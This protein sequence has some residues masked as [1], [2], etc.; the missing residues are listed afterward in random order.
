MPMRPLRGIADFGNVLPCPGRPPIVRM[1]TGEH[2]MHPLQP[3]QIN[4][5]PSGLPTFLSADRCDDLSQLEAD[6]AIVGVPYGVPYDLPGMRSPSATAPAAI[7]AASTRFVRYLSHYDFDLGGPVFA[8]RDIRIIDCGD[9]AMNAGDFEG[10]SQRTTTVIET[11]RDRGAVPIILGGDHA[12]PIP[13]MRAYRDI[14]SM[15][16]IQLDAHIDWRHEVDG[17][18]EGLSSPMR[19]ASELPYVNGMAQFGIR[20]TG[21]AC[22]EEVDA[23]LAYGSALVTA[24]E[25]H[26]RGVASTVDRIPVAENYYI[27]F[28]ADGLDPTI[29]PGVNS[30][31]LGGLTYYQAARLIEAVAKRG[32]IVGYDIVEVVPDRDVGSIT[33][34]TAARLTLFTIGAMAHAGQ[35]GR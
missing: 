31:A 16:M 22:Q 23:A 25:I 1:Q 3:A 27:T 29:A 11:I 26:E 33:S 35:V 5:I 6:V 13:V 7:R 24:E 20:G 28:D 19:R 8:G 14:G 32:K 10:N 34:F 9:V 2:A 17:V 4:P 18:T 12:I 21:S 15:A 30:P